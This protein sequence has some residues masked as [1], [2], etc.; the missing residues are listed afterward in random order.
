VRRVREDPVGMKRDRTLYEIASTFFAAVVICFAVAGMLVA[1]LGDD[2][3]GSAGFVIC[4]VFLLLGLG[5]LYLGLRRGQEGAEPRGEP[6]A[7]P[8][9]PQ[10]PAPRRHPRR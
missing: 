6:R 9:P 2:G 5:R 3:P 10:R 4:A 1:G 8:E 7:E